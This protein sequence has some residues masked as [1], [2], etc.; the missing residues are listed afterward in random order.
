MQQPKPISRNYSDIVR[1]IENGTYQ[2][3]KFQRDFVWSLES[4]A[5][6]ID[7]LLKG[8]PIGSFILW[9]TNSERLKATK[10]L[11]GVIFKEIPQ[12]EYVYYVLDGQ[13][14][15]TSLYL[16]IKGISLDDKKLDYKNLYIDLSKDI[17]SDD[18]ICV[19][20]H[21]QE[22]DFIGFCDLMNLSLLT[23]SEKFGKK[24]AE[25]CELLRRRIESYEFSTIEV[26]NQPFS[27]VA[28]I[29]T[30]INTSGKALTLF[31]IMNAKIYTEEKDGQSGFDLEEKFGELIDDLKYVSYESIAK[32]PIITLQLIG[33]SLKKNAKRD[34]ILSIEKESFIDEWSKAI[35]S[36]KI[37]IEFMRSHL[38]IPASNLLPYSALLVALAYFFRIN[39][40]KPANKIQSQ[41]LSKY[42]F[43]SAFSWRFSSSSDTIL[44]QDIELIEQ[45]KNGKE[46]DFIKK[47]PMQNTSK[48]YFVDTLKENFSVSNAFDKA[49]LCILACAEPRS[50]KNCNIVRL[51]NSWL[52]S[53]DAKNFHHFFPKA[54]LKRQKKEEC[55]NALA[56]ITLVDDYLNKREIRD[57][58]PSKYIQ[59][60]YKNNPDLKATLKTHFI[61]LDTFGIMENDYDTFLQK[62]AEKLASEIMKRI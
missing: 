1:N 8:F 15:I 19:V 10:G 46:I 45:I 20:K 50:F 49:I 59:D 35:E 57:K 32:D 61:D 33:M 42:F 48:E 26:E 22:T 30:R 12:N 6:L 39:K 18:E 4:S 44:T 28:D 31:E 62:R 13:Q 16:A 41:Q 7:S 51:D 36:L 40:M 47:I 53:S 34:G 17:E 9:K 14:R 37:A 23:I 5:K 43:R 60:F 24:F 38:K 27:K 56:N 25:K 29:F 58:A 3:P 2:I 54:Y 21:S 11:G 52:R 55:A